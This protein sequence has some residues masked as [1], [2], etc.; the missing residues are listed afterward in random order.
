MLSLL[1]I[2]LA[3]FVIAVSP[4]PATVSNA[5]VA[6]R[7]G[8][9]T[10]LIYGAGLSTGLVFWGVIAASGLGVVLQSSVYLLMALK[11]FAGLYLIWLAFLSAKSAI[12]PDND[13]DQVEIGTRSLMSWFIKGV[14]LNVS[15]PKTVIAWMAALSVGLGAND[16]TAFL[17]LGVFVC[18]L[19]GFFTNAL[20]SMVFSLNG[21]MNGYKKASRWIDG[22]VS[23][24]FALAGIG[25]IRSAFIKQV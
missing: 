8:R 5:T 23:G 11:V 18:V 19:V 13:M 2:G 25:L 9:K 15:N 3:F 17:V 14:F 7:L 22:S 1:S 4:G 6:M 24:L 10:S 16:S 21:V 20:Y 12:H